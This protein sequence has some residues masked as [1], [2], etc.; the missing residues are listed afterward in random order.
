[1]TL[2]LD[3]PRHAV[4]DEQEQRERAQLRKA[5]EWM[6]AA[7]LAAANAA[8]ADL[9]ELAGLQVAR[10]AVNLG[11]IHTPEVRALISETFTEL[12]YD[13]DE[14]PDG[15]VAHTWRCA[16]TGATVHYVQDPDGCMVVEDAGSPRRSLWD[17]LVVLI[18]AY[19]MHAEKT[20]SA[21]K[22]ALG[23]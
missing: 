15:T 23:D 6:P 4:V 11:R 1:M 12:T 19:Q 10:R 9:A 17:E 20:D 18:G 3:A 14:C 13:M 22:R 8:L 16:N 21:V 7:W 2:T 5:V